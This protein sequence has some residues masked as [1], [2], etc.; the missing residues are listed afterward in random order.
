MSDPKTTILTGA[1][2]WLGS[3]YLEAIRRPEP[4]H[5]PVGRDGEV[6]VLVAVP[7][8]VEVVLRRLPRA[9]VHV[10]DVA[11]PRV[12]TDL[13]AG[14]RD[15]SVVHAAG[16]IHPRAVADF[17]RVNVAG[18]QAVLAAA[19]DAG[20][21]RVVH[22]SS[23]SPLGVN[24]TPHDSFRQHEPYRPY[25]GYG[26]SKMHGELAV[27]SAGSAGWFETVIVRP[28]WFYGPW[29]PARQTRFFTMV[30]KGRFPVPGD[31]RQR[32]SMA[33][34]DNLVQ[35][36]ALAEHHEAADGG[37]FWVADEQ[38]YELREIV[39]TVRR[40]LAEEGYHTA[41]RDRHVPA[42]LARVAERADRSFQARGRYV[43]EAHVLGEMDK[44]IAVDISATQRV[45]GYAPQIDLAEGMRRSVR[46]CRDQGIDLGLASSTRARKGIR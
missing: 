39:S 18:T 36:V 21:R 20:V 9:V 10:G 1:A 27:R 37:T 14:A 15:A 22:V 38:P 11:D 40:L 26:T 44:T 6:R 17:D 5:G 24:P 43:Q 29:Q 46:W 23:N 34:V 3:A 25:L 2:G 12:L 28:P 8:D 35:G 45:L 13:F 4:Q 30:G 7:G 41:A 31:G 16:I 19:R 42:V 32:R 33:Y